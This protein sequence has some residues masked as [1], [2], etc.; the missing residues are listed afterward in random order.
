VGRRKNLGASAVAGETTEI[1]WFPRLFAFPS[2]SNISSSPSV[3]LGVCAQIT[4]WNHPM[5]IAIKKIA[6][7]LAAGNSIVVKPSEFAPITVL[8]FAK[9]ATEVGLPD[10]VF[11]C[12]A[13]QGQCGAHLA[14]HPGLDMVDIT[15]GTPTGKK[16]HAAAGANL[17][18]VLSE[19]GGK[20]PM[21]VFNDA[22]IEEAVNGCVFGSFI[23]SGQTCIAGT[24]LLVQEDIYGKLLGRRVE[25]VVPFGLFLTCLVS[26]SR[27]LSY[28]RLL[29]HKVCGQ[30][31]IYTARGP[32]GPKHSIG[33]AH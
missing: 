16:V 21:I 14:G 24:R 27:L 5:L 25:V 4:P 1:D 8:E 31:E 28:S 20:A 23:A 12:V 2:F 7:A 18:T 6:P 17:C 26:P 10:G 13:G 30:S 22:D 9:L 11:N 3:P 32:A 33:A 15:G 19:L 29:R